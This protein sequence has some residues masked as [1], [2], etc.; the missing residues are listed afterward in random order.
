[1]ARKKAYTD[2]AVKEK[3]LA[4][5]RLGKTRKEAAGQI[6]T[7]LLTFESWLRD[8]DELL[9]EVEAAEE[10]G[11]V[12]RT[13]KPVARDQKTGADRWRKMRE[14]AARF[15]PGMLGFLFAVDARVSSIP[16]NPPMSDF[17]RHAFTEFYQGEY[18]EFLMVGGRGIGK[19][20]NQIKVA[21]SEL[22]FRE[23]HIPPMD[24]R[25]I[26]PFMSHNMAESNQRVGPFKSTL[27]AVGVGEADMVVYERKDGRSE[28]QFDDAKGQPVKVNIFPNTSDACRGGNLCGA[29]DDEEMHWIASKTEGL[30]KADDVLK[31]LVGALRADRSR[32]HIRISSVSDAPNAML[33]A[34]KRGSTSLRYVA[35]L[36]PFLQR[37]LDGFERVAHYI[38][39]LGR[40]G[41]DRVRK[42]AATLTAAS[43][44]IPSWVGNPM[45]DPVEGFELLYDKLRDGQDK[46]GIWLQEN[47]SCFWPLEFVEGN[48]FE[49]QQIDRAVVAVR[50][51]AE[52]YVVP[53]LTGDLRERW[54]GLVKL[55]ATGEVV[56]WH[57]ELRI[58]PDTWEYVLERNPR[59]SRA[60]DAEHF[61]AIDTGAKRNPSALCIVER[62][63]I[64][65]RYQWRPVV[66][67]EWRRTKGGLPLDLRMV[68]LPQMA[69]ILREYGCVSWWS[70]GWGGDV[71]ELVGAEHGI[72]TKYVSTS[73]ATRDIYEPLDVA[74]GQ[75]PCPVALNG[76]DNIDAAV[77]Q[78]RQVKRANDGSAVVPHDGADHGELGQVLARALAHAGVGT[79]P[80][81]ENASKFVGI[82][83]RYSAFRGTGSRA[84]R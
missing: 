46:V 79:M 26:W 3:L 83:D 81:D 2:P 8:D 55:K 66:L 59:K 57:K 78:L 45:H 4:E 74:L 6:M 50:G 75:T 48:Y 17:F 19:S 14:D 34:A 38:E 20:T 47:G 67:R 42:W 52:R 69:R 43:P 11:R 73:T 60:V 23:R 25:W 1:M 76:C 80:P 29:T 10:I 58:I 53:L 65:T 28:I 16:G 54:T 5:L 56:E 37:A 41:A 62:V 51:T 40:Q 32:V 15:A 24:P 82:P 36:G 13:E 64:G 33:D 31:V 27:K 71:V 49:A 84:Y 44:W 63:K 70:D 18:H 7:P 22:L 61:A 35:T 12:A 9:R 68:V 21:A 77:A 30:S 39:G 72:E